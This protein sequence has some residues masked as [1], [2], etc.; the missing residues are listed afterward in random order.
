MTS[1]VWSWHHW[2][3]HVSPP[4]AWEAVH[5]IPSQQGLTQIWPRIQR[6]T[7]HE[8]PVRKEKTNSFVQLCS[9]DKLSDQ[10][11]I[12]LVITNQLK[13]SACYLEVEHIPVGP[14]AC[15]LRAPPVA[16]WK[17]TWLSLTLGSRSRFSCVRSPLSWRRIGSCSALWEWLSGQPRW[18][19]FSPAVNRSAFGVPQDHCRQPYPLEFGFLVWWVLKNRRQLGLHVLA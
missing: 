19:S 7:S 5:C 16:L 8:L 6:T 13:W 14:I 4:F 1:K 3:T 17:L 11:Y 12:S 2:D 15:V 18:T 9:W 10:G